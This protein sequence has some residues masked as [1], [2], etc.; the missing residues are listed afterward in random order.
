MIA[1]STLFGLVVL[2]RE[3]GGWWPAVAAPVASVLVIALTFVGPLLMEPLFNRFEP[4]ADN[5]LAGELRALSA[6]AGVP[7]SSVLVADAS[8][9]TRRQNAYVSGLGATRRVVL[10]DTLLA[11]SPPD[12]VR[13]VTA[14]ELAHR[15]ERHVAIGSTLGAASAAAFVLLLWALLSSESVLAAIGAD[16]AADPRIGAFV[17]LVA[18][19]TG[20]ITLP[21]GSALSR[22]W[23]RDADRISIELTRDPEAY[24]SVH[25]E[26]ATSNLSDLEPPAF[27][28]RFTFSHPTAPERVLMARKTADTFASVG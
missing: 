25:R 4:L 28:Y 9:R 22:R 23:E 1:V 6:R 27:F 15:R 3:V 19:A 2:I 20:L 5:Q 14:H 24:E 7:V 13:L 18:R 16:G 8:R 12:N 26:L 21:L 17:L 10:Y 11:E